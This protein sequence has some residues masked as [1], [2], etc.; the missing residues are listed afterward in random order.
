MYTDPGSVSLERT[1]PG[2]VSLE[3]NLGRK[4]APS[5]TCYSSRSLDSPAH[6]KM[7]FRTLPPVIPL[8]THTSFFFG[9]YWG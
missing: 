4:S 8:P 5:L 1:D 6:S 9:Q 3:H 7:K 2:S